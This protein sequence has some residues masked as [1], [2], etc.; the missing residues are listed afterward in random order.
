M[1]NE[2]EIWKDVV[3]YEG[4]YQVSSWGNVKSFMM[5]HGS[6]NERILKQNLNGFGY[7]HVA[8]CIHGKPKTKTVHKLVAMAFHGFIP[9]GT[10]KIVI[11]HIDNNR[12]NNHFNNLQVI[13][14]RENASKDQK[15]KGR[16]SKYIGVNYNII[17]KKW[18]ATIRFKDRSINLGCFELEIDAANAYQKARK[19]ADA[20]LDLDIL[21]PKR[22]KTSK[23]KGVHWSKI[24]KM[25]IVQIEIKGKK[26]YLG[27]FKT[28]LEAYEA[29][30]N[31][32]KN[33]QAIS[34]SVI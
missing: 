9:D 30:Q 27:R 16:S 20:G 31:Y 10:R 15:S 29:L 23:Y 11:D 17:D 33:L 24:A 13:P 4:L 19:E 28:E 3:G 12:Q 7:L 1:E 34:E 26:V 6:N 5:Y 21:Y 25:W 14:Q 22:I 18:R 32:I 2:I 8:L